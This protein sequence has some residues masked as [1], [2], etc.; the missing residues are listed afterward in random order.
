MLTYSSQRTPLEPTPL[1]PEAFAA[2]YRELGYWVEETIPDFLLSACRTYA[3]RQVLVALAHSLPG[4][5][6][7]PGQVRW[8]YGELAR[9]ATAAA[10]RLRDAGVGA[11]DRV[12]LQ[13]PNTAEYL[14]Y[15]L[16]IFWA[17]ALPVFCLPQHRQKELAHFARRTDAAAHVFSTATGGADFAALYESYAG[18]LAREGLV[19]PVAVDAAQPLEPAE[20]VLNAPVALVRTGGSER[21]SEQVAFLQ[22]S[23]GTTGVS[24]LIPRTHAAYLYSVRESAR[25]CGLTEDT[26]MLVVL[27]AAHNF[28]MSSPGI[29][30]AFHAG[31]SLIFAADPSP[32]TA[33]SLIEAEQVTFAALVPPLAQAWIASAERRAPHLAS[34]ATVQV[35]GAKLLP[36]VAARIQP[37]LGAH[38]QQVFGMA[39][40]LVNYTRA[41]DP[42]EIVLTTQG[43]PI[44]P[45][46]EIRVVDDYDRDVPEGQSGHLLTRGPYTIRGYYRED[47]ANRDGFTEDGFYR[48]GDIVKVHPGGH[49]EVTGRAKDQINRNGEKIAVDEIEDLALTHPGIHD[50]VALGIPDEAVGERVA[51]VVVPLPGTVFTNARRELHDF[52]T[53]AGLAAYKIP[54]RVEVYPSLPVTNIGKISR[55]ELREQLLTHLEK[56]P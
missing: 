51:L 5:D 8:T 23:G 43:T 33:F 50:A 12:L 42:Q 45:D 2:R 40:G 41:G 52:F 48:T 54:E 4:A 56:Q 31:A 27:P 21:P 11:G 25:I 29:L 6:G 20:Q 7:K 14:V 37:V 49:I 26:R 32:Q 22:L 24:K 28:T 35:G 3:D 18:E 17:G 16:G 36:A 9:Y 38:L 30:G 10:R 39:E 19:P 53:A 1:I 15:L 44:S 46:D 55:R 13:L 34:L 47:R